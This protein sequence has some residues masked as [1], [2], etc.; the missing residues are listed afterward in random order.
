V[1]STVLAYVVKGSRLAVNAAAGVSLPRV[2]QAEK[3]FLSHQQVYDLAER[4]GPDIGLRC[5]S[6]PIRASDGVRWR[7][8]DCTESTFCVGACS[9]PSQ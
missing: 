1:L 8:S 3:R 4:V 5:C 9:W 7:R 2:R 6:W